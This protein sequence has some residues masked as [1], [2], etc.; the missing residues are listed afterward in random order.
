MKLFEYEAKELLLKKGVP[1]PKGRVV[2]SPEEI[3][4][5]AVELGTP[6]VIKAQVLTGGRGKSGLVQFADNPE[7]AI[8]IAEEIFKKQIPAYAGK[9]RCIERLLVEEKI[10]A[11][12]EFYLSITIDR[13]KGEFLVMASSE[14]GMEIE[15]IFRRSPKKI[16]VERIKSTSDFYPYKIRQLLQGIGFK[17]ISLNRLSDILWKLWTIFVDYDAE[18]VEV[19]PLVISSQ[20]KLYALDAKVILDDDALY[21]HPELKFDLKKRIF[22]QLEIEG[23]YADINYVDLTGNICIMANGAGLVLTLMDLINRGGERPANFLDTGGGVSRDDTYNAMKLILKKSNCDC[24]IKVI[25]FMLSLAISPP[26]DAA[27]GIVDALTEEEAKIPIIACCHGT[28]EEVAKKKLEEIGIKTSSSIEESVQLALQ[29]A[30][31][32]R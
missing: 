15:E 11:R 3:G 22:N 4:G 9:G 17:G 21:R 19:N 28:G 30:K 24:R 23:K 20:D 27:G 25:L 32:K 12:R 2:E 31:Q 6:V 10:D 1:I 13:D 18:I 8:K 5:I 14:G 29:L 26:E 7:E 16:T